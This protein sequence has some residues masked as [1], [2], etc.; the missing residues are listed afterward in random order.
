MQTNRT[1]SPELRRSALGASALAATL[2]LA[3]HPSGAQELDRGAMIE[4][5]RERIAEAGLVV[6]EDLRYAEIEGVE[7]ERLSLDVYTL[8][9]REEAPVV[10]FVHGGGWQ[11]GDK[12]AVLNKPL[13][14][15]PAGYVVVSTN[16][17]MRPEVTVREMASDVARAVAWVHRE[18]ARFGG[19]GERIVLMGHSAGAHL[20]SVVGTNRRLLEEQGVST[21]LLRGVVPLDTG[22]YDVA[23]QVE[24]SRG[25]YGELMAAVFGDDP[26][27]WPEVSPRLLIGDGSGLPPFLVFHHEGR[28]D[29]GEQ[30]GPFVEALR[31]AG[32]EADLV[33]A[34]G[35]S[36]VSLSTEMGL[37]D[38]EPTRVLLDFLA[39]HAPA[40]ARR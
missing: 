36:H 29:V 20:V 16:T 38:D 3:M 32:V 12:K 37:P 11:R 23:L 22:P 19:D 6:H 5:A 1:E 25:Q 10:L 26:A 13:A 2:A 9:G 31:A 24:R 40:E 30:A 34:K 14:L 35:R 8:E 18:I 33:E 27:S 17:R 4:S 39:R 28:W 15:V 7:P 21:E